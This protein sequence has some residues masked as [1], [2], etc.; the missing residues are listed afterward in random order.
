MRVGMMLP[1]S[2]NN[3]FGHLSDGPLAN[4]GRVQMLFGAVKG[5]YFVNCEDKWTWSNRFLKQMNNIMAKDTHRVRHSY[6]QTDQ[7][8]QA[9]QNE[10]LHSVSSLYNQCNLIKVKYIELIS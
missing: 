2:R 6:S 5:S 7:K 10:D 3:D 1:K 4:I 8:R 9:K